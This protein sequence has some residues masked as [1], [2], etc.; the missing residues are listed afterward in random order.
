MLEGPASPPRRR[1][2]SHR[3]TSQPSLFY[4]IF[5]WHEETGFLR[6]TMNNLARRAP[7]SEANSPFLQ[8]TYAGRFWSGLPRVQDVATDAL[9]SSKSGGHRPNRLLPSISPFHSSAQLD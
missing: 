5:S 3:P 2:G 4:V 9:F 1:T 7:N 8:G 6:F